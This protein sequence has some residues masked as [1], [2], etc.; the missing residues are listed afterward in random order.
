M[1]TWNLLA[2]CSMVMLL[3]RPA[4]NIRAVADLRSSPKRRLF[5]RQM[6]IAELISEEFCC[7]VFSPNA[8][9]ISFNLLYLKT[10][11]C[12]ISKISVLFRPCSGSTGARQG[13]LERR[14]LR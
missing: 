14:E 10:A 6:T 3:T 1:I 4:P 12:T 9:K 8:L 13:H 2:M 11:P 7:S 5:L